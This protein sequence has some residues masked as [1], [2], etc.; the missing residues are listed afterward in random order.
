[1]FNAPVAVG[2]ETSETDVQARL[3]A[4]L[5][6]DRTLYSGGNLPLHTSV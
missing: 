5:G 6:R 4:R 3:L 2:S 1:M